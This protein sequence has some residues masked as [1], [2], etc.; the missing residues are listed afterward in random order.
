LVGLLVFGEQEA[1]LQARGRLWWRES[2]DDGG[3]LVE[4]YAVL[5][6][7]RLDLY[8]SEEVSLL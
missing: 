1:A 8:D 2:L 4:R 3:E 7:G 5:S 6:K